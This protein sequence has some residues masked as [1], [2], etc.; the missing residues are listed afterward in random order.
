VVYEVVPFE[1]SV[2]VTVVSQYQLE[3]V[4]T[5]PVRVIIVLPQLLEYPNDAAGVASAGQPTAT[6]KEAI[7]V[8]LLRKET[9][10]VPVGPSN[11]MTAV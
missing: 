7:V 1:T 11:R 8:V 10:D 5:V 6:S 4:G 3:P 2:P 9:V